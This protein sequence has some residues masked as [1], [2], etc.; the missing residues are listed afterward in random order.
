MGMEEV[1]RAINLERM[2]RKNLGPRETCERA[3][4]DY[5]PTPEEIAEMTAAIRE[6]WSEETYRTRSGEPKDSVF[7]DYTIP[8][9]SRPSFRPSYGE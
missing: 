1:D 7:S 5:L 9:V 3:I 6:E 8:Q 4:P 2:S